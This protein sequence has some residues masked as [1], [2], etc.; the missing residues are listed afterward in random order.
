M[1]SDV[2][3]PV[4]IELEKVTKT[5]RSGGGPLGSSAA[6]VTALNSV[7]LCIHSGEIFGLVGESGSGKTTMGR[8]IVRLEKPDTGS[9]KVHG[10]PVAQLRKRALKQFRR[11]MQMIFQ[12]PYQSLNPY[13]SVLHTVAEPLNIHKKDSSNAIRKKVIQTLDMVGLTPAKDFLYRYPH[14]LSG[15]QRQ[16]VA[17]ARAMVLDPD[18]VVADEP[19][20]MLDASISVQIFQILANIQSRKHLTLLF[21]THSLAAAHYLCHRIAVIYRG[22]IVEIGPAKKIIS[23]PGHPYTQALLDALPKFGHLWKGQQFNTLRKNERSFQVTGGC[24][25]FSRCNRADEN[26]CSE[27]RPALVNLGDQHQSACFFAG[28]TEK[29]TTS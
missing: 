22:H 25:F 26:L 5:Y 28:S 12:D 4:A 13:L 29:G 17:I 7:D 18:V 10:T 19:T 20:S 11:Q 1:S 8:L 21:I 14:Q 6:T 2:T 3:N 15:G 23:E 9:I 24:P 27:Q 16:R